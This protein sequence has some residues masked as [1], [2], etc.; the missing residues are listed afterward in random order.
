MIQTKR[1]NCTLSI[2]PTVFPP[3]SILPIQSVRRSIPAILIVVF[4]TAIIGIVMG[5]RG[6]EYIFSFA[7]GLATF[8]GWIRLTMPLQLTIVGESK[9]EAA[10]KIT[11]LIEQPSVFGFKYNKISGSD[12]WMPAGPDLYTWDP[13]IRIEYSTEFI[14]VTGPGC[15]IQSISSAISK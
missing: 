13:A 4:I 1:G 14:V 11:E 3:R 8:A 2:S 9:A 5:G 6:L 7:V 10:R 12:H 15:I